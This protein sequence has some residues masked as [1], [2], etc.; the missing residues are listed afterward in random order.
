MHRDYLNGP[1]VSALAQ[2]LKN[3]QQ[4]TLAQFIHTELAHKRGQVVQ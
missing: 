2:W 3:D 4:A 1:E